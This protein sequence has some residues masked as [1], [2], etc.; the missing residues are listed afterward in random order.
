[1][2]HSR[3]L[4]RILGDSGFRHTQA[5][6][7]AY[8]TPG[9]EPWMSDVAFLESK[10]VLDGEPEHLIPSIFSTLGLAQEWNSG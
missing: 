1:M 4:S 5:K 10:Q 3:Y 8:A 6:R 9:L 2:N 7:R